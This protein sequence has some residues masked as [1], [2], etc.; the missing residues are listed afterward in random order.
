MS[1][2]A[3]IMFGPHPAGTLAAA[4]LAAN[5]AAS[6]AAALV[7]AVRIPARRLF[8]P[9]GAYPLWI[10]PPVAGLVALVVAMVPVDSDRFSW[11]AGI[12][13]RAPWLDLAMGLWAV[14]AA[15]VA[16]GFGLAQR[17][18]FADVRAGR[19]GPAVVGLVSPRILMPPDDGRY[20][21]EERALIR[22][23]E[24]AHVGRKDPRAAALASL[25]Q[26]LCWWNPMA[27]L[28]AHL[29][30]L[31]QELACDATVI[32]GRP[33][34]RALY[35]KTLFK[36]QLASQPLPFGCYWPARGRHPLEARI[37]LLKRR[38]DAARP[39][40]AGASVVLAV[41]EAIRP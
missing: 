9:D 20:T 26:C 7:M 15:A 38:G 12:A 17:R 6:A 3:Y 16:L 27:H 39:K 35:A 41:A 31:D 23:H 28:A 8:G 34:A 25:A 33:D 11:A 13:V 40:S 10:V 5:A 36:T 24:R 37:A 29:L 2:L 1:D 19:G 14:V 32:M 4:A 30:R 18:F 21:A 22:A